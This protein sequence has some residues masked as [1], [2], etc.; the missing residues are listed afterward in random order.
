[1]LT[2]PATRG[3]TWKRIET[4]EGEKYSTFNKKNKSCCCTQHLYKMQSTV[5]CFINWPFVRPVQCRVIGSHRS[6]PP[7]VRIYLQ[8]TAAG[9]QTDDVSDALV[10]TSP[11]E[12]VGFRS[13]STHK[14]ATL[15]L[16]RSRLPRRNIAVYL[17]QEAQLYSRDSVRCVKR[18][19][20]VTQ[21][22][23]LLWQ[24]TRH[25]WLPIGI[26]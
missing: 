20:K 1:M 7:R 9:R 24:S 6:C 21:G 8:R 18:P 17:Q 2:F 3:T 16:R 23:L 13:R 15:Y 26:Q 11:D 22:H 5:M 14:P 25:I 12:A 10:C 19:F 4:R